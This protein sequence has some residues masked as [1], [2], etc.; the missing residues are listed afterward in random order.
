[1]T[2]L[3]GKQFLQGTVF[4]K[5][6]TGVEMP[7]IVK[8][9]DIYSAVIQVITEKGYVGATTRQM[10]EAADV[11]EVTLFRKYGSRYDLYN[12]GIILGIWRP[13]PGALQAF[14]NVWHCRG[15]SF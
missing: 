10:A 13:G 7:K 15:P 3:K 1:M 6:N 9:E 8:D 12:R 2:I 4:L 14:R 5:L 11:S